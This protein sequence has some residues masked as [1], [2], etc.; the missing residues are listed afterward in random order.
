MKSLTFYWIYVF[1]GG[2]IHAITVGC[3]YHDYDIDLDIH[4]WTIPLIV[5]YLAN[6]V[7]MPL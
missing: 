7:S 1:V 2:E 6:S 4:E 5:N 3:R